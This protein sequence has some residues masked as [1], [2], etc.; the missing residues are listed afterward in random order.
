[1][2]KAILIEQT[3]QKTKK[4]LFINNLSFTLYTLGVLKIEFNY[5]GLNSKV[6]NLFKP[7]F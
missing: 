3:S 7:F 2:T 1:M 6:F 4:V 5:K